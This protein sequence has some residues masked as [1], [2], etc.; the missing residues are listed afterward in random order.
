MYYESMF[1]VTFI[2]WMVS[3][4]CLIVFAGMLMDLVGLRALKLVATV[5]Y[6]A[7]TVMFALTTASTVPLFY[8]AGIFVALGSI[9]S[10]IC[11]H[12]VSS[13]FPQ[14]RGLCISLIS[15]AY[16]SSTVIAFVIS[17][18]YMSFSFK[19][20][21]LILAV[22]SLIVGLF[23]AFFILTRYSKDMGEYAASSSK[24][25]D[26][27]MSKDPSSNDE[28]LSTSTTIDVF[29]EISLV[30]DERYPT[31][32][33]C[34]F[35]SSYLL[36]NI[37]FTLGLFR[38]SFYLNHFVKHISSMF[39]NNEIMKIHLLTAS[40]GFFMCGF[41][42]APLT[43]TIIDYF[44]RNSRKKI[45]IILIHYQN[46]NQV[47]YSTSNMIYY[48]LVNGLVPSLSLMAIFAILLSIMMF[49][50]HYIACY[51]GFLFLV[52][53]RSL[54]FS[55]FISFLLSVFPIR[56]FGTLNGISSTIAGLFSL[57]QYAF[58]TTSPFMDNI[59]TLAIS[60]SISI[61]PIIFFIQ[62]KK[63]K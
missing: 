53:I 27:D 41:F 15:G 31:L 40:S 32:K 20:S 45:Q 38:F 23:V 12:Q 22:C 19:W 42:I 10:L 52:V 46:N 61:T 33:S 60:L 25:V 58:L 5:L 11:N 50:P 49:I 30:L 59:I 51:A 43:G 1:G 7:G 3:Q 44:L 18:T 35:S 48:T 54:L 2:V 14:M 34:L 28:P 8:A 6:F 21:F 26:G 57:I 36:I 24:Q 47:D 9:C 16:D 55:S 56:Y 4:M 63:E 17:L 13:M 62:Y 29:N 37:W 39:N